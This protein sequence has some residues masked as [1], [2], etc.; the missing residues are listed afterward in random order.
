MNDGDFPEAI[1]NFIARIRA[2]MRCAKLAVMNVARDLRTA[3]RTNAESVHRDGLDA[4][5]RGHTAAMQALSTALKTFIELGDPMNSALSAAAL[6]LT[7][8]IQ[9]NYR[10]FP[11]CIAI[12][13]IVR[14]AEFRWNSN[15]DELLALSGL[16]AGLIFFGQEDP[17]IEAC[18][19]RIMVLL[20]LDLDVNVKFAAGRLV[21]YY[22]EPRQLR[23]LGQR[24][25]SLLRPSMGHGD[26]TPHRLGHWL[27]YWARV[28]RYA[29]EPEQAEL[30]ENRARTLAHEHQLRDIL[31]WLAVIDVDR[32]LPTHNVTQ[33]ESAL[34]L[35]EQAADPAHLGDL[36]RLEFL[37][38]KIAR[39]KGQGD[40]AV[41]HAARATSYAV[42]L[43][44]PPVMR[45]V[46][47]V[48]EAQARLLIEDFSTG[49]QLLRA[50]L[51]LVPAGYADEVRD[52]IA[53]T[54]A[55]D[56]SVRNT[57][58][59]L[60][61]LT[62]A[63][64]SIRARQFYDAFDGF[65]EF[66][67][68]LCVLALDHGIE[69]EFVRRLIETRNIAP[70]V[71]ASESW[72]WPVHLTTLGDFVLRR[73]SEP[74]V[75]QTKTQKKPIELLKVLAA[76][77]G[78]GVSKQKLYGLLWPDA[79]AMA[80]AAALD[81]LILRL[82][83]LLR[84]PEAIMVDKGSVGLNPEH[85]WLDVWSFDADVESLQAALVA[86]A[87]DATIDHLATRLLKRYRG[88]FLANDDP[89]RW[90]L[91]ARDRW[92]NRFRRSLADAGR[93][94]ERRGDWGRAIALYERGVEEDSLAEALY[95]A[96]MRAYV[97]RGDAAE[98][99]S[100]Y[101]RCRDMLSVQLGIRPSADTEAL[102]RSIYDR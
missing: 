76:L 33:A 32:S 83:K 85:V 66:G 14:E 68:K 78:R 60:S 80:S 25:Y 7:A 48:N 9:A 63:W 2:S 34:I 21:M 10:R 54:E 61:L 13:S 49:L 71:N 100:V 30:A 4:S 91:A 99:A 35:A 29:R 94:W 84:D 38:T 51:E 24:V 57:S 102:F 101:R 55:Y 53:L 28:A 45:A 17:F 82:R 37:K 41:F 42:E 40:R 90:S 86:D 87:A 43:A 89:Q 31:F 58:G 79:D 74:V 15:N 52:M 73:R 5:H 88:P 95:R 67:A 6:L 81:V 47:I 98:A 65:P 11:E 16:L 62:D 75:W 59:W 56:A 19:E 77:G 12:L 96:L 36:L 22:S 27:V 1:R 69:S 20:E 64:A 50:A 26:L 97:A 92:Q 8:Q 46:Y 70:P 18:V 72:P 44:F 3:A 39:M 23:A 93:Y